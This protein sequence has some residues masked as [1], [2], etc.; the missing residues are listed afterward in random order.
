MSQIV[1]CQ[2][3]YPSRLD[4]QN[5]FQP[6]VDP[7]IN[8]SNAIYSKKSFSNKPSGAFKLFKLKKNKKQDQRNP[9]P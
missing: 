9:N 1:L 6:S 5:L 4:H 8:P 3:V 2:P 7:T